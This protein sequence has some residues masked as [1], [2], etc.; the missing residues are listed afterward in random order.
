MIPDRPYS[1][2]AVWEAGPTSSDGVAGRGGSGPG[3]RPDRG[4]CRQIREVVNRLREAGHQAPGDANIRIVLD[5]GHDVTRPAFLLAGLPVVVPGRVRTDRVLRSARTPTTTRQHLIAHPD[6]GPS[7]LCP[8]QPPTPTPRPSPGPTPPATA[9]PTH[10]PG[11]D[12][13]LCRPDAAPGPVTTGRHRSS[14]AAS[15]DSR[16]TGHPAT[17]TP[18]RS[19]RGAQPRSRPPPT[20]TGSGRASCAASTSNTPSASAP[21]PWAGPSPASA[22]PT[23]PTAGPGS[24]SPRTPDS[25]QPALS[26]KTDAVPGEKPVLTP[27]RGDPD[28]GPPRVSPPPGDNHPAGRR[29]EILPTR[30]R[31]PTRTTQQPARSPPRRRQKHHNGHSQAD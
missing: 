6:T 12:H 7:S 30:P 2:V 11:P 16:W 23:P 18:H 27:G 21:R 26:P 14:P 1:F 31:P 3:R 17:G 28:P 15:S 29:T 5:A 9:P 4:R 25:D 22:P 20:S 8:T 19:G 24:S 13:T 10:A